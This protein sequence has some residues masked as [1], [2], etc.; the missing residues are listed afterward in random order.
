MTFFEIVFKYSVH[1]S[2]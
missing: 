1:T 2:P